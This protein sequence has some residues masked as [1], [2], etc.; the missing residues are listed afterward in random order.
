MDGGEAFGGMTAGAC[1]APCCLAEG[2][3]WAGEGHDAGQGEDEEMDRGLRAIWDFW[4]VD[5]GFPTVDKEKLGY[6]T[7]LGRR[8]DL[9]FDFTS[10]ITIII[11][12]K[13]ARGIR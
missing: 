1:K 13:S 12:S 5:R 2:V 6:P 4:M 7:V 8:A 10:Y 11:S 9:P 3:E